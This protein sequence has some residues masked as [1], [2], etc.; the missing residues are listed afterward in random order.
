MFDDLPGPYDNSMFQLTAYVDADWG[1]NKDN[2]HSQTGYVIYIGRSIIAWASTDQGSQSGS[3]AESELK[4]LKHL[5]M[6]V[7]LMLRQVL[8]A[9]GFPQGATIVYEDNKAVLDSTNQAAITRGLR[10]VDIAYHLVKLWR[11]QGRLDVR[12]VE[13]S[14]NI[15]DLLTKQVKS[16]VFFAL[17]FYL[18][19]HIRDISK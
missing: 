14:L 8:S 13:S 16:V 3:T 4:A 7:L 17:V 9:M 15:A 18:V 6:D 5:C 19:S 11:A 12:S 2:R 1:G 10:Y